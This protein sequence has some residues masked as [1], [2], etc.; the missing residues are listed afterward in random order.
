MLGHEHA[1]HDPGEHGGEHLVVVL[2]DEHGEADVGDQRSDESKIGHGMFPLAKS[3][4][5]IG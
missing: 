5:L 1:V 4:D 3:Y 2:I